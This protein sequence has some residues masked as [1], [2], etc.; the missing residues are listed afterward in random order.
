MGYLNPLLKLPAARALLE[1]DGS[2]RVAL[3][4]LMTALRCEANI[5]A[6]RAWKR[7]KGPM[8]CYWRAVSTY[9]R[10]IAHVL[11]RGQVAVPVDDAP[12]PE[13]VRLQRDLDAAR[14]QVAALVE[15]AR[16]A[17]PKPWHPNA[18]TPENW[19]RQLRRLGH[20]EP[21][22]QLWLPLHD[23][24]PA[25]TSWSAGIGEPSARAAHACPEER[26]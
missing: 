25:A 21:V 18:S 4:A 9:A 26:P 7:R 5:E 8:A 13:L 2:A 14:R 1:L 3:A 23:E 10:H 12:S 11:R 20:P 19:A 6:E 15:A 17:L 24:Q 16:V 22:S